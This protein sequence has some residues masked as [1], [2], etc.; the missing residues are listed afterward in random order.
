MYDSTFIVSE[1]KGNWYAI[2]SGLLYG[3][4]G[5]F[6]MVLVGG[7]LSAVNVSFW[8]FSTSFL[9]MA[10]IFL[11]TRPKKLG[12]SRHYFRAFINGALFYSAPSTLFF[13]ASQYI[14]TGQSMVIFFCF[15]AF[16]M[17]LNKALYNNPIKPHY[18]ASFAVIIAGLVMLVDIAEFGFDLIGVALSLLSGVSYAFY[19]VFSKQVKLSALESTIMVSLGC[20]TTSLILALATGTFVVPPQ[21]MQWL[22]IIGLAIISTAVPILLMLEA[23]K[24]ISSDR[25][26]LLA[27]LE[28]VATVIF[29]VILLH[30]QLTMKAAFGIGLTLLG[31]MSISVKW[32]GYLPV[33]MKR[34]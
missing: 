6:G 12:P 16:V 23:L 19:V 1:K 29:G 25:A 21:P 2:L 15:P 8:R 5:Y 14:G 27:V 10:L 11:A 31:A 3:L 20:A 34:G 17:M 33:W 22:H 24:H 28:P 26:S 13:I 9:C 30:E 4:L 18:F 32:R 7:G